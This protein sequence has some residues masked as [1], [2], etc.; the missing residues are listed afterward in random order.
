VVLA[1]EGQPNGGEGL[2]PVEEDGAL[3]LAP[4]RVIADALL[5][6]AEADVAQM[7]S[8]GVDSMA[9]AYFFATD[10]VQ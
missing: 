10:L 6:E 1:V 9:Y 4:I 3:V 2:S 8:A 7:Q 5:G